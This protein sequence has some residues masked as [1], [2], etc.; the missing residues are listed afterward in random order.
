MVNLNR[1]SICLGEYQEKE[2]LRIMPKCGHNFHLSCIDVWLRKQST[3]P[4][5]RFPVQDSLATKRMRHATVSL[6]RSID[7]PET[8]TEHSRQWLLPGSEHSEGNASHQ[9][10]LNTVHGNP[11]S[12]QGEPQ[13]RD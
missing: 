8:S 6:V 10:N 3:C 13:T 11:E 2:V 12:A 9:E 4:V 7:S 5:C 1:C